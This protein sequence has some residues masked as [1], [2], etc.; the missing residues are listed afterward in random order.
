MSWTAGTTRRGR[1][2]ALGGSAW[3]RSS[4]FRFRFKDQD[5]LRARSAPRGRVGRTRTAAYRKAVDENADQDAF[6]ALYAR[7]RLA[8]PDRDIEAIVRT[9]GANL[10]TALIDKAGLLAS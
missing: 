8:L 3:L 5:V 9:T 10:K 4:S 6:A 1:L 7:Q 2:R